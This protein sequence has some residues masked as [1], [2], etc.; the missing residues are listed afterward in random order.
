MNNPNLMQQALGAQWAQLPA[1]LQAHYT[2]RANSDIG[3]LDIA[4]PRAMQICLNLL[5]RVG[6]LINRRGKGVATTVTKQMQGQV[7]YWQR[8]LCYTDGQ[9]IVFNSRWEYA[10]GNRLIE[11]V[12]AMLGLCM[13]VF[14]VDGRL[15]YQGLY[16][17][18]QLGSVRLRLPEWLVLGHTSIVETALDSERFSMDFRLHHPVFGELYRYAGEFKTH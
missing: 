15:H 14:V 3:E 17:V 5:R 2:E 16:Y 13:A 10:G 8:T 6:A 7:Q 1:A 12:N 11:Y 4:Y 9:T 18:V